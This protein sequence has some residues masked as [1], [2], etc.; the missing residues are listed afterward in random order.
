M[1]LLAGL[2]GMLAV[3]ATALVWLDLAYDPKEDPKN[4]SLEDGAEPSDI[5]ATDSED[6]IEAE[7][8]AAEVEDNVFATRTDAAD[9]SSFSAEDD[10]LVIVFNDHFDPDPE[11]GL[12]VDERD[13]SRA[14]VTLNGIRIAAVDEAEGL[15]LDHIALVAQSS[16]EI[17]AAA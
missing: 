13:L 9:I 17:P 14:H 1:L 2:M 11:V 4:D 15:T 12:E 3:G 8:D 16:V 10:R 7:S 6:L 5:S